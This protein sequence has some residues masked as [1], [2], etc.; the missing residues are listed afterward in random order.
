MQ[1]CS[2][3]LF[4]LN[5]SEQKIMIEFL[6]FEIQFFRKVSDG[7]TTNMK[8]IDLEMLYNFIVGN[9]FIW[10]HL[11]KKNYVWISSNLKFEFFKRPQMDKPPLRKLQTSKSYKNFVVDN[12]LVWNHLSMKNYAWISHIW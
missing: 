4:H 6:T 1:L 9:I 10:N 8:G 3:Q 11:S 2:S 7:E 12:F 5:S